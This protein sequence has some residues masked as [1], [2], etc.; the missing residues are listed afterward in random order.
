MLILY[1]FRANAAREVLACDEFAKGVQTSSND[2]I[3]G[4][5]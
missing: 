3:D 5:I 2:E 4:I 1:D